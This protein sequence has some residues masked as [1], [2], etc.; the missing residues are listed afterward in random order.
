MVEDIFQ[1]NA[2]HL[3]SLKGKGVFPAHGVRK[4]SSVNRVGSVELKKDTQEGG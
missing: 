4:E 3:K 1:F 2:I